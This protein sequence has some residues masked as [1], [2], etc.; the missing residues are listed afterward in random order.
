MSGRVYVYCC[1]NLLSG[2]LQ[3]SLLLVAT[4]QTQPP[5]EDFMLGPNFLITVGG[6]TVVLFDFWSDNPTSVSEFFC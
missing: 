4:R 5:V 6:K 1:Q 3:E 2:S